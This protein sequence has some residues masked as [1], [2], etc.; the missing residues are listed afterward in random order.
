[1]A[2]ILLWL[3]IA[4]YIVYLSLDLFRIAKTRNETLVAVRLRRRY[5]NILLLLTGLGYGLYHTWQDKTSFLSLLPLLLL[6]ILVLI[7][8]FRA[9]LW[10]LQ[11]DGFFY[12]MKFVPYTRIVQMQLNPNGVL[13]IRLDNGTRINLALADMDELEKAA[14][15]FSD[16]A[17]LERILLQDSEEIR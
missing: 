9:N 4:G 15:F 6:L 10:R 2:E 1:M 8:A 5:G 16:A 12:L 17:H 7:T 3:V 13:W 14:A 11:A